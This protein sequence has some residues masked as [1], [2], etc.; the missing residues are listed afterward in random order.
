MVETRWNTVR[1]RVSETPPGVFPLGIQ[2]LGSGQ[3]ALLLTS[4][5]PTS[6]VPEGG[7]DY[8]KSKGCMGL[9]LYNV[10]YQVRQY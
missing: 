5:R 8:S 9:P 10:F 3:S 7:G 4:C 2:L 1:T 6:N